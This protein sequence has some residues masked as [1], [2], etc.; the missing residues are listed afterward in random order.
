M[1]PS[2]A[3][4]PPTNAIRLHLPTRLY[5]DAGKPKL[6]GDEAARVRDRRGWQQSAFRS[7]DRESEA[8]RKVIR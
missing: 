1:P 3:R 4:T 2:I 6:A 5:E 8:H 7:H